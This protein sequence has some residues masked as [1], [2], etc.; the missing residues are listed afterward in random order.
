MNVLEVPALD[1]PE[2]I[3]AC[4]WPVTLDS[5]NAQYQKEWS[6][7]DIT[8]AIEIRAP[9]K[10]SVKV[11]N[12]KCTASDSVDVKFAGIDDL[13]AYA[14]K[15]S[16]DFNESVWFTAGATEIESW[17]WTFGDGEFSS[18]PDPAHTFAIHGEYVASVK[19]TN[20]NGCQD[21]VQ[22]PIIVNP[23]L[24]I[25]NVFTPDND[26]KNDA[27]V[28]QYNG[29]ESYQ[30]IIFNRWGK[31]VFSTTDRTL[32]W[33]GDNAESGV[34]WYYL[35]IGSKHYKGWVHLLRS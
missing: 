21:S 23:H 26:D 8:Q 9:G 16:V 19:A 24:F 27:F 33:Q 18:Q 35:T 31:Q 17:H 12:G 32:F 29:D 14:D 6:T 2:E 11:A 5:D 30:L 22:I 13:V 7:G 25:P 10:Y 1:L 4:A 3:A 34:Y 20:R 15:K 28:I